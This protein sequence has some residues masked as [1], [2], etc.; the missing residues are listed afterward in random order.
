MSDAINDEPNTGTAFA[1][2]EAPEP[3]APGATSL[4]VSRGFNA[5]LR[6]RRL[7]LAF[8]SYQTGQLFLVGAH[9]NG[10]VSFNQ[11]NF[12]RAMGVCWR[13]G[14]LYLGSLFQL[15]RL[16]N[17]LKP[18]EVANKAFD[19]ALV[20]RN[21]QTTGDVD[22]HELG[23]DAQGRVIFVNTSYSCLATLDLTHSFK[24]LWKPSFISK[25]APEDRCH[26]NGLAMDQGRAR[27]VTCVSRS[28]VVTGWRE[29]RHEGGMLIDVETDRVVTDQ[30]SMPHSPRVHGA[31]VYA[32]DSGRGQLIRIDPKTGAK[33]DVA[34]CPG[35]LRGLAIHD[36]HAVVTVSKPRNGAFKGLLLDGELKA[37]DAEPWCGVLIVN[38][39]NGDIVEWIR[40]E[41]HITELFDVAA[42]PG[43]ACPMS[44]GPA[45]AEIHNAISFPP[46]D[47]AVLKAA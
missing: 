22:I 35:F 7:S 15:W 27:Y 6:S 14:R 17:M 26:L 45:S 37:R 33:E 25:L 32:L 19:V 42:M 11:Q 10:T 24:P 44:I 40:L 5:W 39:A 2:G 12:T 43:V 9:P 29:R 31:H 28:D 13:S 16:E 46:I 38:L 20:P 30:L 18:G 21:A 1:P 23:V 8:T 3:A 47:E 41:G 34:F 36:G 4:T